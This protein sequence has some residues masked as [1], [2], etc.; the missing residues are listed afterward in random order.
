MNNKGITLIEL[1]LSITILSIVIL[2]FMTIFSQLITF[3]VK[4]EDK[5]TVINIAEEVLNNVKRSVPNSA[6]PITI[7]GKTYYPSISVGTNQTGRE[8]SLG[9]RRVHVKI[10]TEEYFD[11]TSEPASEIY[12]YIESGG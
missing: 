5:V 2:S 7:N 11:P 10:Y 6:D 9:L 8:S 4:V 12:G 1:L 3:S